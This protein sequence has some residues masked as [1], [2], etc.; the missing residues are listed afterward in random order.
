VNATS[1][2]AVSIGLFLRLLHLLL[3]PLWSSAAMKPS[4]WHIFFSILSCSVIVRLLSCLLFF[5]NYFTIF[6]CLFLGRSFMM[7]LPIVL[8]VTPAAHPTS[9]VGFWLLI[10]L[11]DQTPFTTERSFGCLHSG[12]K[13]SRGAPLSVPLGSPADFGHNSA[14]SALDSQKN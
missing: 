10:S 2:R 12:E 13:K 5:K 1:C 3:P 14:N 6:I 11:L 4:A 9:T 7:T 8:I